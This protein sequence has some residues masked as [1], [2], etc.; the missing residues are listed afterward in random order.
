MRHLLCAAL[1]ALSSNAIAADSTR[2]DGVPV[3]GR[4]HDLSADDLRE[5]VA[6]AKYDQGWTPSSIEVM[7][8]DT[9]RAYLPDRELGWVP[10][11]RVKC[12]VDRRWNFGGISIADSPDVQRFIQTATEAYIF[13]DPNPLKP[14]REELRMRRLDASSL[15]ELVRILG[16]DQDW[17]HGGVLMM[18]AVKKLPP[19]VGFDFRKGPSELV[20]F[21]NDDGHVT[22]TFNGLH[23]GG[24][25]EGSAFKELESWKHRYAQAE[26]GS[27]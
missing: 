23:K 1:V 21:I 26:L 18:G 15:A 12:C 16:Y 11:R 24:Y 10:G 3:F 22:G 25:L 19:N 8:P 27:K 5:V 4:L 17:I 2:I 9:L 7:G 20:L 13:P 6:D 14:H